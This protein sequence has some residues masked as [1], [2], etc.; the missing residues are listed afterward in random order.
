MH[1]LIAIILGCSLA[2]STALAQTAIKFSNDWKW[3]GPASWL[4]LALDD[5]YFEDE[6]LSVSLE[7]GK[8]SL[9]AIPRVASGE[10]DMGSA[11]INTLIKFRDQ[12]PESDLKGIFVIYNSPP[13]AVIGRP[14]RGVIGPTDLEGKVLGAPAADGAY[15]QWDAFIAANGIE[16]D[17]VTIEDVGFPVR[18]S[19]LAKGEV[20]AITGYSFSSLINLKASGVPATDISLMLMSDF[21]LDLYGNVIIVNSEFAKNHPND[22]RGFLRAVIKGLQN[23]VANPAAAVKHVL[24]HNEA[25]VEDT[26]LS[27]L[28]MAIGYHIVTDE[29]RKNGV[30]GVSIARLER[31]IEQ[32]AQ[33]YKF[34]KRP[35][36]TDVFDE[37]YLP[38]PALRTLG[39][40]PKK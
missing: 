6:G 24:T 28:I 29:V 27:R 17:K 1:R 4:L 22:V 2:S 18:E 25:A 32:I 39:V 10:F 5:G 26:E 7:A 20:D 33:T 21:G 13:F 31:S 30:G 35:S 8:G 9:D 19:M 34:I 37:R 40:K 15:A 38:A 12:N 23:T 3:E 11:D 36:P 14:S 16:N